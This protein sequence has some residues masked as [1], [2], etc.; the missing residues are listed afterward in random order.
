MAALRNIAVLSL[1]L[2]VAPS[3]VFAGTMFVG[4]F[5]GDGIVDAGK[6]NGT[7]FHLDLNGNRVWNGNAGGDRSAN[8]AAFSGTGTPLAGDWDNDGADEVGRYVDATAGFY[9]D[10]NGNGIWDGGATDRGVA[11]AAS[12]GS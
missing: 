3:Q 7:V 1:A 5:N 11:F 4:D 9:L 6:Q 10:L 2:S 12:A 8:F